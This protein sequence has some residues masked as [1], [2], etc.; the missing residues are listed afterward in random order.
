MI[1]GPVA[2]YDLEAFDAQQRTNVRGT[3]VV[4]R[5]ASRELRDGGAI[6]NV[7]S[8]VV[9]LAPRGYGAYAASKGAIEA[10]TRVLA[11]E[12]RGREIT[13]NAVAP[14]LEQPGAETGVANLI[15]FLVG[16]EGHW[17]NGKVIRADIGI[18]FTVSDLRTTGR[19]S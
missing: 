10:I 13:V 4:N 11:S 17:V 12:L 7:F 3:F 8:S 15:A 19:C 2:D 9:G 16:E 14:G 5:Q 1:I 6:V 18:V